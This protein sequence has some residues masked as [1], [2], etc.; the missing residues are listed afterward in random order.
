MWEKMPTAE[1]LA[2]PEHGS[3]FFDRYRKLT[4]YVDA[5]I[6]RPERTAKVEPITAHTT[7]ARPMQLRSTKARPSRLF[8]RRPRTP[9]PSPSRSGTRTRCGSDIGGNLNSGTPGTVR[10]GEKNRPNS[11]SSSPAVSRV[12]NPEGKSAP[13]KAAFARGAE[14]FA[15][16]DRVFALAGDEFDRDSLLLNQPA[17]TVN[18][19]D[20]SFRA[21]RRADMITKCTAVPPSDKSRPVF[22]RFLA[23]VTCGDRALVDYLQRARRLP[24]RSRERPLAALLIRRTGCASYASIRSAL[25]ASMQASSRQRRSSTIATRMSATWASAGIPKITSRSAAVATR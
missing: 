2:L 7:R 11:P 16:A 14:T 23:D 9:S 3:A 24:V 22:D 13:S 25:R 8:R 21:H 5:S 18:L 10:A 15:R 6:G 20:G 12:A 17:G 4:Q 1:K 19:R